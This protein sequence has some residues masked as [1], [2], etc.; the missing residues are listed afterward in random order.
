[1]KLSRRPFLT[2]CGASMLSPLLIERMT[3]PAWA[4]DDGSDEIDPIL[5][6][7]LQQEMAESLTEQLLP[8]SDS[9]VTFLAASRGMGGI[10]RRDKLLQLLTKFNKAYRAEGDGISTWPEDE[11]SL[12]YRHLAELGDRGGARTDT[13]V[14]NHRSLLRLSIANGYSPRL[15]GTRRVVFGLRGCRIVSGA[16]RHRSSVRLVEATPNHFDR[17]CVIGVW[18]RR[19]RTVAVFE[20]STVPN[21]VQVELHWLWAQYQREG[22]RVDNPGQWMTNLLPQGLYEY[23]VG[24]HLAGAMPRR[25]RQPGA[26]RQ[27]I[28]VP[29]L[30]AQNSASFTF[31]ETWDYATKPV[32][33][34]IHASVYDDYFIG[35]SS[36]GCQTVLGNYKPK[37]LRAN[38]PWRQFRRALNLLAIDRNTQTTGNDCE[39]YPYLLTTGREARLHASARPQAEAAGLRR[40]RYGSQGPHVLA[41]QRLLARRDLMTSE[42]SG[43]FDRDSVVGWIEFQKQNDLPADAVVTASIARQFSLP[44]W[45]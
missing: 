20:G 7:V 44:N 23:E 26:L 15:A 6:E 5:A 40:V 24:T 29:V 41:V 27:V 1:M 9:E 43:L 19:R 25:R 30:R 16:G 31:D 34:N 2:L 35:F 39:R 12:D 22:R 21:R 45:T 8:E 37:G 4:Q 28:A 13:F 3:S 32:G 38:G 11:K 17:R 10:A 18:D 33:D 36:Q 14:L 42:P